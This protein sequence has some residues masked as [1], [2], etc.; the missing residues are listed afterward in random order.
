MIRKFALLFCVGLLSGISLNVLAEPV[1]PNPAQNV[2]ASLLENEVTLTWEAPYNGGTI[3]YITDEE[4]VP[5]SPSG[6]NS[7]SY[8]EVIRFTPEDLKLMHNFE[9]THVRFYTGKIQNGDSTRTYKI[10]IWEGE[11]DSHPK[12]Q[13][14][15]QTA[16]MPDNNTWYCIEL[17]EAHTIDN[18]KDLWIG[19]EIIRAEQ[20]NG[21]I[22]R[23]FY[24]SGVVKGK[25]NVMYDGE[26]WSTRNNTVWPISATIASGESTPTLTGYNIKRGEEVINE[27]L[28]EATATEYKDVLTET[29]TED[30]YVYSVIAK[31]GEE[32]CAAPVVTEA[33]P[34]TNETDALPTE[35]AS[36]RTGKQVLITWEFEPVVERE[37]NPTFKI[38]VDKEVVEDEDQSDDGDGGDDGEDTSDE[39]ENEEE[40]PQP[41]ATVNNGVNQYTATLT[42]SGTF[43]YSVS[44]QGA[45]SESDKV[46]ADAPI[47]SKPLTATVT[48]NGKVYDTTTEATVQSVAFADSSEEEVEASE[49]AYTASATFV[50]AQAG[51]AKATQGTLKLEGDLADEYWLQTSTFVSATIAPADLTVSGLIAADKVYDG[52][53]TTTIADEEAVLH[54]ILA[55]DVVTWAGT[56]IGTFITERVGSYAVM[57][58]GYELAGA[59]KNNYA[60]VPFVL[61]AAITPK[62]LTLSDNADKVYDGTTDATLTDA[63]ALSGVVASDVV[64]LN[65]TGTAVAAFEDANVGEAIAVTVSGLSLAGAQKDNY[66]LNP[67]L[68]ADITPKAL[69]ITGLTAD[70]KTY[71]GTTDATVSGTPELGGIIDGDKVDLD[72]ETIEYAFVD[73]NVSWVDAVDEDEVDEDEVDAVLATAA[74][75][76]DPADPTDPTDEVAKKVVGKVDVILTADLTGDAAGNYTLTLPAL[77]AA[78]TPATITIT[79]DAGQEKYRLEDDP[80]AL[81]YTSEGW[82][83]DDTDELLT[84]ALEREAGED[85]GKY[86]ILIGTL[87]VTSPNYVIDFDDSVVF[88]IL[89]PVGID[90]VKVSGLKVYPNPVRQ[91]ETLH[92]A[93]ENPDAIIRIS[94]ITGALLQQL[95]ATGLVTDIALSLPAGSYLLSVNGKIAKFIVR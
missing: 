19:V 70:D 66:T 50:N 4:A 68:S 89:W 87:A 42:E 21:N 1:T 95:Q 62:T 71:D 76:A 36:V 84:G 54:G 5:V 79:P 80:E 17:T 34:F 75:P 74:D 72:P 45:Y 10:K 26:S 9:V 49:E 81:T 27:E 25:S 37:G 51:S 55:E 60:V 59:D 3:S 23:P 61:E 64:T 83:A 53:R 46:E 63:L 16:E 33:V 85:V 40:T 48:V 15:C 12:C 22:P 38:Y 77:S 11:E 47:V 14:V 56:P 44:F 78:I 73:A 13:K 29:N 28:L 91:G 92:I 65:G 39:N 41:I 30:G 90:P 82:V 8:T 86:P 2:L 31:Y 35:V 88:A 57:V 94:S 58:H 32:S 93:S 67:V 24:N 69:T 18:S 6:Q 52:G 7:A 43:T 20:K